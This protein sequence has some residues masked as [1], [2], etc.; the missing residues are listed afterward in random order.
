MLN[1]GHTQ[2]LSQPPSTGWVNLIW[3]GRKCD[4]CDAMY[5]PLLLSS[6]V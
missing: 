4:K 3:M 2:T 1:S 6:D 5:S